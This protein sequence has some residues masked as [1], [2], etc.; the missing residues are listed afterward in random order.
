M[1]GQYSESALPTVQFTRI[2]VYEGSDPQAVG[3]APHA[4]LTCNGRDITPGSPSNTFACL[5]QPPGGVYQ[6]TYTDEHDATTTVIVHVPLGVFDFLSPQAGSVVHLPTNGA[7]PV[8][9]SIPRVPAQGS[10]HISSFT[11]ACGDP[12]QLY[13]CGVIMSNLPDS[14]IITPSVSG[15]GPPPARPVP[16]SCAVPPPLPDS[17]VT[18]SADQGTAILSGDFRQLQPLPGRLELDV[19]ACIM[20][21]PA[22]F[23]AVRVTLDDAL[24]IPITWAR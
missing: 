13:A 7:L 19:Q 9:F 17:L 4:R 20:P 12:A 23:E 2:E 3:L 16:L 11:A 21:D 15:F 22:G 6:I 24:S 8:R 5:R 14:S 10:V 18:L 1:R